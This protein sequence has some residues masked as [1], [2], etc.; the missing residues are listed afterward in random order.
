MNDRAVA[1]PWQ[2][3]RAWVRPRLHCWLNSRLKNKTCFSLLHPPQS[4]PRSVARLAGPAQAMEVTIP[5]E[6]A[7]L[8]LIPHLSFFKLPDA[9][10][11]DLRV[12]TSFP[13]GRNQFH[14]LSLAGPWGLCSK[15]TLCPACT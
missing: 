3:P 6:P 13:Q 15:S 1:G 8:S 10:K 14:T 2:A 11:K 12:E 7:S 9:L 5:H 4:P